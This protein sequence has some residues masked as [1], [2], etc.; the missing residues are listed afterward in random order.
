MTEQ[1]RI[2]LGLRPRTIAGWWPERP[3]QTMKN[4]EHQSDQ[5]GEASA[6]PPSRS[7]TESNTHT[8]LLQAERQ[9]ALVIQSNAY[10]GWVRGLVG[11]KPP[12]EG[13]RLIQA[14][15][16]FARERDRALPPQPP[17]QTND[18]SR[19]SARSDALQRQD[20]RENPDR[21]GSE[22]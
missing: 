4:E 1:Q 2:A 20:L 11:L 19:A 14:W 9:T 17:G 6:L 13:T 3:L 10:L 21:K 5:V 15:V 22:R 12:T 7:A 8:N 18:L 16:D